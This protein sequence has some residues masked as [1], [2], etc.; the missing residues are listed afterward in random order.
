MHIS[1]YLTRIGY[2]GS[3]AANYETLAGLHQA[4]LLAISYENLNIHLGRYLSLDE[5]AIFDKLVT[6]RRGGWCYEMNGLFAWA[7]R[8][9]GFSVTLLASGVNRAKQGERA[10]GDH[11][12]LRVTLDRPYL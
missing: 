8:E 11:L 4:H 7:L 9:L 5:G 10:D 1:D 6:A 12:I 2:M 3:L